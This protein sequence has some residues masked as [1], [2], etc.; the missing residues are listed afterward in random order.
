MAVGVFS[1]DNDTAPYRYCNIRTRYRWW[2]GKK[3]LSVAGPPGTP[4]EI[5]QVAA[6]RGRKIVTFDVVRDRL[7]P[8]VPGVEADT[9]LQTFLAGWLQTTGPDLQADGQVY[10]WRTRGK[11]VYALVLPVTP[12]EGYPAPSGPYTSTQ[13]SQNFVGP[14]YF[15][16]DIIQT[17]QAPQVTLTAT[18]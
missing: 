16:G 6:P 5:V 12:A 1:P 11:W 4:A 2:S 17:P 10:Q 9:P 15:V 3:M 18:K 13:P 8:E 14:Q 7:P